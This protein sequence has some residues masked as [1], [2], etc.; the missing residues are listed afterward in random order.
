MSSGKMTYE[1]FLEWCDEDIWKKIRINPSQLWPGLLILCIFAFSLYLLSPYLI[2]AYYLE[3]GGREVELGLDFSS[4][5]PEEPNPYFDR[6]LM[7][8][9]KALNWDERNAQAYRQLGKLYLLLGQN[10]SAMEALL[11]ASEL[12]PKNP[13]IHLELGDAYDA[14]G[15]AKE[16]LE[17]YERWRGQKLRKEKMIVNYIK[18]ADWNV[19]AGGGDKAIRILNGKVLALDPDNLYAIYRL[20]KI[21]EGIGE[22]AK[23]FASPYYEKLR[24]FSLESIEPRRDVRLKEYTAEAVFG[25]VEDEVWSFEDALNVISFW[26]WKEE[27]EQA[28]LTVER[29]L[30]K[31]EEEADL[32][33]YLAQLYHRQGDYERA[34]EVLNKVIELDPD[35]APAYF[36]MGRIY[37]EMWRRE[38]WKRKAN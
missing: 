22:E 19:A 4:E 12:R 37:E 17:E 8:F 27:Y 31:F 30:K 15:M 9:K 16:A 25:L 35:Y 33:Y 24:Y 29:L 34:I 2:S 5:H 26:I 14:L 6:A 28:R 32:W 10:Q 38:R 13:L 7:H 1:D 36:E 3:L 18:M 23:E 11:K 21:Y 20:V